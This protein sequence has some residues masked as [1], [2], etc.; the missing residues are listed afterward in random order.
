[1]KDVQCMMAGII[2]IIIIIFIIIAPGTLASGN[3]NDHT[4]CQVVLGVANVHMDAVLL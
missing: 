3:G 1:M 4:D 2:V